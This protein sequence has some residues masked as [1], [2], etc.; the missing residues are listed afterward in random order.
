M[1]LFLGRHENESREGFRRA[2]YEWDDGAIVIE[3]G[4]DGGLRLSVSSGSEQEEHELHFD[5][6]RLRAI[7]NESKLITIE[8]IGKSGGRDTLPAH[9]NKQS[10][11]ITIEDTRGRQLATAVI[12]VP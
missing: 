12:V 10:K 7:S 5:P 8:E 11:L 2:T 6:E 3:P 9:I 1:P 4:H